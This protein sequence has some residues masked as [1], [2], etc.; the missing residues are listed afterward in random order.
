M[1]GLVAAIG[2]GGA[3]PAEVETVCDDAFDDDGDSLID[4]EDPDCSEDPACQAPAFDVADGQDL[5][6]PDGDPSL[7]IEGVNIE[8]SGTTATFDVF[9]YGTWPPPASTYSWFVECSLTANGSPVAVAT[10][11]VH[12]GAPSTYG[13]G[14]SAANITVTPGTDSVR[15]V[16]VNLPGTPTHFAVQSGIQKANPGNRVTDQV[17]STAIPN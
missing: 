2:C 17:P 4:C 12:A 3:P 13:T 6:A 7:D 11:Q 8:V 16:L 14:V 10:T 9:V 5:A 1:F 15:L